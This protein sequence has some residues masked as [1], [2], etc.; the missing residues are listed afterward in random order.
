MN[1]HDSKLKMCIGVCDFFSL[2]AHNYNF[3]HEIVVSVCCLFVILHKIQMFANQIHEANNGN[4]FPNENIQLHV[5]FLY[6]QRI[7][8]KTFPSEIKYQRI[9]F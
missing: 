7:F 4:E 6:L 2:L 1:V 3:L 5:F 9:Q 8:Q